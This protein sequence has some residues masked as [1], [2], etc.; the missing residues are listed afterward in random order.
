M[1]KTLLAISVVAAA[2]LLAQ[3]PQRGIDPDELEHIHAAC[4]VSWGEVPYRDFFEHHGPALYYLLQPILRLTGPEL[5]ALWWSRILMWTVAMATLALTGAIAG[6]LAGP[7]AA[8]VAMALLSCTTIFFQKAI[9][10]R[11][12]VPAMFL[13]TLAAYLVIAA[14]KPRS[15][16]AA[17]L[18]GFLLGLATLFTQKAIVP[19]AALILAQWVASCQGH[20][21]APAD[22]HRLPADLL[23][24][25]AQVGLVGLASALVWIVAAALFWTAGGAEAFLHATA[26]QLWQWPVRLSPLV[27]LRPTL[28]A[29]LTLWVG[30]SMAVV[31]S[32]PGLL[33][34]DKQPAATIVPLTVLGSFAGGLLL[35]AA[36]SQ[37]YLLWFPLLA[38]VAADRLVRWG[39]GQMTSR[40]RRTL[41]CVLAATVVVEAALA[42][43]A[44]L[45][46]ADGAVPH[47]LNRLPTTCAILLVGGILAALAVA[48][49]VCLARGRRSATVFMLAA[50][51]L[52]YAGLRN[53]DA[54]CWS[55]HGQVAAIAR[56]QRLV[57]PD[58]TVFDGYTGLG[59]FR[60][61]A[62]Y[63]WWLNNYSLRLIAPEQGERELLE[64]LK[65]SPPKLICFDENLATLSPAVLAWIDENYAPIEPP[66]RIRKTSP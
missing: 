27:T 46:G 10:V 41:S 60:R 4:A 58:E 33:R 21:T 64:T 20:S 48:A 35:K 42:V 30:G 15:I 22:R 16:P 2:V 54:V 13:L 26:G 43:R 18:V 23:A 34:S 14:R 37:Y 17:I 24:G 38:V 29:D 56:V 31:A 65:R 8:V 1:R 3:V 44:I 57:G 53:L 61:H 59:A 62:Y 7:P 63:Y 32:I 66:L 47:L 36:Y 50:L 49:G 5:P 51:G 11:P 19:A 28:S 40:T 45:G 6:R 12:D 55:N 9:E 39:E 52:G 25:A